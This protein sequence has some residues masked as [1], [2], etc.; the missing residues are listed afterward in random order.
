MEIT[1]LLTFLEGMGID[2]PCKYLTCRDLLLLGARWDSNPR[3]SEPQA[4]M[5]ILSE[6]LCTAQKYDSLKTAFAAILRLSL[7]LD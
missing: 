4:L 2:N 3:H 6:S 1:S 7:F 5:P